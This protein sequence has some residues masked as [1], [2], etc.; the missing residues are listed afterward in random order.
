MI[1]GVPRGARDLLGRRVDDHLA[2]RAIDDHHVAWLHLAARVVQADDG[3]HVERSRQD[4]RVIG[5]A[6][7]VGGE[8]ADFGPVH[9]RR[10]RR[11]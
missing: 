11:R 4:R 3:R 9:L 1:V 8:A 6:A 2:R 10:E 7:G 5:A